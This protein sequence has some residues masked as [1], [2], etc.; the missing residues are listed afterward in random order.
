M[1][2][3]QA[4]LRAEVHDD[5][6]VRILQEDYRNAQ[7]SP[8]NRDML[9]FAFKMTC[10][11]SQMSEADVQTLRVA[12]FPDEDIVDIAQ[13]AAYFNYANRLM[14]CLGIKPDPGMRYPD[15]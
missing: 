2:S 1:Q 7:L 6:Q 8:A 14:D 11:P 5:A 10:T 15:S 12:G 4:D 9:D 13:I 3:H